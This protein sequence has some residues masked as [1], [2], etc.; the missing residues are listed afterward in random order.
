LAAPDGRTLAFVSTR[1]GG[2]ANVWTLDL[3]SRAA[4]HLTPHASGNFRPAWLPHGRWIA[5]SSDR[6]ADAGT[7]PGRWEQLQSLGVY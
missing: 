3:A 6:D 5:F 4:R 7:D 2:H 1:G